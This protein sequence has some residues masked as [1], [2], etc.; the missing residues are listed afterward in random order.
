MQLDTFDLVASLQAMPETDPV[1]IDGIQ[2]GKV[3]TCQQICLALSVNVIQSVCV[4][5]TCQ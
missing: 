4:G 1:E 3:Q 5:V 2:F